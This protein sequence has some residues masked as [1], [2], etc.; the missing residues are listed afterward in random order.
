[1]PPFRYYGITDD[2][3]KMKILG[4]VVLECSGLPLLFKTMKRLLG[5]VDEF[6]RRL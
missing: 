2:L 6:V 4:F 3:V 1:M 5:I